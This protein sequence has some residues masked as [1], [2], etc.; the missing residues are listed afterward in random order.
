MTRYMLDTNTVSDLL[1]GNARSTKQLVSVPITSLCISSV[2]EGEMLYGLAKRPDAK[3]L[4][5]AVME[6]LRRLDVLPWTSNVAHH[7][8]V[9][10]ANLER[11]GKVLAPLDLLI[12]AHAL[13]SN[14]VLVTNDKAF[15]QV[16]GLVIENWAR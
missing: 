6:L 7:Y 1:R 15:K 4:H 3:Q 2:T 13:A 12:A 9:M 5:T 14:A 10:R 16:S 11:R 8:G